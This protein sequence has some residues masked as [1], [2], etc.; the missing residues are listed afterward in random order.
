MQLQL[1]VRM[2][3]RMRTAAVQRNAQRC[4]QVIAGSIPFEKQVSHQ[5]TPTRMRA[6]GAPTSIGGAGMLRR[7][8]TAAEA[9]AAT[10]PS[11]VTSSTAL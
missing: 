7:A 8:M 9:A 6:Q 3:A 5:T 2:C 10:E 11:S 4:N 1:H